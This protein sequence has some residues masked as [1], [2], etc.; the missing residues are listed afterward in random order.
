MLMSKLNNSI[1]SSLATLI[2]S[3]AQRDRRMKRFTVR[4]EA[5][6]K[7]SLVSLILYATSFGTASRFESEE[8]NIIQQISK[9]IMAGKLLRYFYFSIF[10]LQFIIFNIK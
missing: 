1:L 6:H 10:N 7:R 8:K 9:M 3:P 2:L 5:H 4:L